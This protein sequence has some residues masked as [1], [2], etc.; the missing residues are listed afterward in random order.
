MIMKIGIDARFYGTIGKG[1][2]RYVSELIA[3]LERIDDRNEYV[4]FLRRENFD[5][6]R[7]TA[8]NFRKELAEY[9]CYSLH[10]QVLYPLFLRRFRLDLMHFPHFNV[11]LLY[12][13][14]FVTTVHDLILLHFPTVR[15]TTLN[16][17]TYRLKYLA[18]RLVMAS[19]LRRAKTILTV[20][21]TTK[22]EIERLFPKTKNKSI[23][24]TGCACSEKFSENQK[25]NQPA[26]T[27]VGPKKP[28]ALYVGSAYPHKNLERLVKGFDRF[29]RQGHEDFGLVLVGANDYF[30]ERLQKEMTRERLGL[31][32]TFFGRASDEELADLYRNASFYVFPSLCEGFGIPP[33]EAMSYGLPVVSSNRSCLPETLGQAALY[34]DPEDIESMAAAMSQLA[35]DEGLRTKLIEAGRIQCACYSWRDTAARTLTVYEQNLQ[36][37]DERHQQTA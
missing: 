29:R 17:L 3:H 23:V 14:P 19:A 16:P 28:Y 13:R 5:D 33:L 9:R 2:G 25:E 34:F 35:D 30:Y 24:V 7:P 31:G 1:L 4:I 37:N 20:S 32:V 22:K 6:Y 36:K 12:R 10:E 8:P 18:Y 11:P 27:S 21:E 26:E 15:S